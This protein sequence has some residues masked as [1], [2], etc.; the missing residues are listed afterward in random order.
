MYAPVCAR[1]HT[2]DVRLDAHC[3]DYV[4]TILALPQMED[5]RADAATEPEEVEELEVE[6]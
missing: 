3:A 6:F 4:A 1:F 2:Y 5:W